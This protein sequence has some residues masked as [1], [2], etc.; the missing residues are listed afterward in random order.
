MFA[1]VTLPHCE[2]CKPNRKDAG[3]F[4]GARRGQV[5]DDYRVS[6]HLINPPV[7]FAQDFILILWMGVKTAALLTSVVR[8]CAIATRNL[9]FWWVVGGRSTPASTP[10][11][12]NGSRR[13]NRSG[14]CPPA[15]M[16]CVGGGPVNL[17]CTTLQTAS[18]YDDDPPPRIQH[19]TAWTPL[20]CAMAQCCWRCLVGMCRRHGFHH[21][22]MTRPTTQRASRRHPTIISIEHMNLAPC[23]DVTVL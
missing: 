20:L 21:H 17:S 7:I 10:P 12:S 16:P 22:V 3:G 18:C 15:N 13:C 23:C 9:C 8:G 19:S 4:W 6:I 2:E 14:R 11:T 1:D 5:W